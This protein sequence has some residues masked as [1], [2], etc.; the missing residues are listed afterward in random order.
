MFIDEWCFYLNIFFLG[1]NVVGKRGFVGNLF[2]LIVLSVG[3]FSLKIIYWS[4]V[5][6]LYVNLFLFFWNRI[7]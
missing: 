6:V 3:I 4:E 5:L 1:S 2:C 7:L